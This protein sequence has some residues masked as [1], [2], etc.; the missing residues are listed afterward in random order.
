MRP[1]KARPYRFGRGLEEQGKGAGR[2]ARKPERSHT[3]PCAGMPE[4]GR[5]LNNWPRLAAVLRCPGSVTADTNIG[6]ADGPWER[7][8][9]RPRVRGREVVGPTYYRRRGGAGLAG[10]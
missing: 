6:G 10:T 1:I 9:K 2:I 4:T 8:H 7:T 5:R 3:R